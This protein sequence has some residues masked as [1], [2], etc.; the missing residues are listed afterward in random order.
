MLM[1]PISGKALLLI[2]FTVNLRGIACA[3]TREKLEV[4]SDD[5][6]QFSS[7][8]PSAGHIIVSFAM[9]R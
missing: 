5:D 2:Y 4:E 1:G 9:I 8:I 7:V 6:A 3:T